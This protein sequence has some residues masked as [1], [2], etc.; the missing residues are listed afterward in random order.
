MTVHIGKGEVRKDEVNVYDKNGRFIRTIKK[1]QQYKVYSYDNKRYAIGG[2]EYIEVQDGV[3]YVF[4]WITVKEPM[5]LYR[6][7]GTVERTLNAGE[8]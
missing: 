6:P 4:G 1:G 3:T 2:G 5:T 7:D 8:Q